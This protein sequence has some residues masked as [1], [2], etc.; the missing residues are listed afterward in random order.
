MAQ[1]SSVFLMET[2]WYLT[3]CLSGVL[4][5]SVFLPCCLNAHTCTEVNGVKGYW[6]SEW[7]S[8]ND[9]PVKKGRLSQRTLGPCQR[10]EGSSLAHL[11]TEANMK[12]NGGFAKGHALTRKRSWIEGVSR[13]EGCVFCVEV[14]VRTGK[15]TSFLY[16]KGRGSKV[17]RIDVCSRHLCFLPAQHPLLV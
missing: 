4:M 11:R 16:E 17:E 14:D 3:K 6:S 8:L 12:T 15:G 9:G 2:P 5:T 7:L 1:P 13:G 10:P